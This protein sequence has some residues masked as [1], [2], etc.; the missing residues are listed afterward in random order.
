MSSTL[1]RLW[2]GPFTLDGAIDWPTLEA[3]ARTPAPSTPASCRSQAA[4]AGLPELACPAAAAERL[5]NGNPMPLPAAGL[6]EGATA[7]ASRDGVPL[8]VGTWRGGALH[9]SRVFVL[10]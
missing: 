1:R 3:E 6:A 5:L 2:S 8:A 7:W 10:G 4:L 9:P